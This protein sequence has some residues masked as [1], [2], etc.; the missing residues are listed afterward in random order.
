[1][2]LFAVVWKMK[3]A[4][5]GCGFRSLLS[6]HTTSEIFRLLVTHPWLVCSLA[7]SS[8]QKEVED[9]FLLEDA[10]MLALGNKL[11]DDIVA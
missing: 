10:S 6:L 5:F 8:V 3:V 7:Q 11:L 2:V 1:M 9:T 4:D